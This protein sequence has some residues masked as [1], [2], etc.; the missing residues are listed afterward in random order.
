MLDVKEECKKLK[1]DVQ[2]G[3]KLLS[4]RMSALRYL[5]NIKEDIRSDEFT[6]LSEELLD[7]SFRVEVQIK[8]LGVKYEVL[9]S[10]CES[11]GDRISDSD[12][13]ELEETGKEIMDFMIE[14]KKANSEGIPE[15][16]KIS[17]VFRRRKENGDY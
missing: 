10:F 11:L 13:Q 8:T 5:G 16:S 7:T 6:E 1:E 12:I 4:K 3:K 2:E 15:V 14:I 9:S 17:E